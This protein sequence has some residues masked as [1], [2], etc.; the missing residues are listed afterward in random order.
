VNIKFSWTHLIFFGA[1]LLLGLPLF[2]VVLKAFAAGPDQWAKVFDPRYLPLL[3][4]TFFLTTIVTLLSSFLGVSLAFLVIKTDLPFHSLWR[5]LL[6]APLAIPTYVGSLVYIIFFGPRGM[7]YE[8]IGELPFNIYGL[9]GAI[10]VMTLFTFPYIYLLVSAGLKN[11]NESFEC[12]SIGLGLSKRETFFRCLL[13]M[14]YPSLAAGAMLVALY[15][16]SDFGAIAMLRYNTFTTAIYYQINSYNQNMAALLSVALMIIAFGLLYLENLFR[17][18]KR[19]YQIN[20]TKGATKRYKLGKFTPFALIFVFTVVLFSVVIPLY[21]LIL[22]SVEGVREGAINQRFFETLANSVGI[23]L[24]AVLGALVFGFFVVHGTNREG[25]RV[26]KLLHGLSHSIY[27]LPGVIIALGVIA[28]T[29]T[30]F[31]IIYSTLFVVSLAHMIRFL[32]QLMQGLESGLCQIGIGLDEAAKG[33]GENTF[34]VMR[35]IIF[36]LI[37]PGM[38]AGSVIVFISSLKELPAAL[39]LRPP[40]IDTLAVRV[41]IETGEAY[42]DQAAPYAL[43]LVLVSL[44]PLPWILRKYS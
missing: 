28:I 4:N 11:I 12:A 2:Y 34:G 1:G 14:V 5:V 21:V 31:P 8:W 36:P 41:W 16:L 43:C 10:I 40:G 30:Y 42:Y 19:Y 26:A 15:V 6:I 25:G 9:S 22:W 32:P 37:R 3:E 13:P 24:M 23:S 44:L 17:K 39:L 29:N 20:S 18:K 27:S 7:L 35:R 33:L 38:I